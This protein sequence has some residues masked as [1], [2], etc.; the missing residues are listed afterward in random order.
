V[1]ESKLG[2]GVVAFTLKAEIQFEHYSLSSA[3]N[4][5]SLTLFFQLFCD[6][7]GA[8]CEDSGIQ[9]RSS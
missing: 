4:A 7:D 8:W 2:E 9:Q 1:G 6:D 5:K 3:S